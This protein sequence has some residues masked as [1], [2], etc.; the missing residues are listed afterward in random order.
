M[1]PYLVLDQYAQKFLQEWDH[2]ATVRSQKRTRFDDTTID[3]VSADFIFKPFIKFKEIQ[4]LATENTLT[5]RLQF[6][7]QLLHSVANFEVNF[8]TDLCGKLANDSIGIDLPDSVKQVALLIGTDEMYHAFVARE[9]LGDLKKLRG[10]TPIT[11]SAQPV[12]PTEKPSSE[13]LPVKPKP[14]PLEFFKTDVPVE[15][16][17]IG[18]TTLLCILENA[19]VDDL[20]NM[21][22]KSNQNPFDIYVREHMDDESRHKV[23]FQQLLKYIWVTISEEDRV[24]LGKT[25][26][27]YF[28]NYVN[29]DREVL[30]NLRIKALAG[31]NLSEQKIHEIA[32][33]SVDD[34]LSQAKY[35]I[36]FVKNPMKL[37]HYAG[38]TQH[39]PTRDLLIAGNWLSS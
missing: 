34:Q 21:S 24:Y 20:I 22:K 6:L 26:Y 19:I 35:D 30:L 13:A 2:K 15:L 10:I 39:P 3:S 31:L 33:A 23:F 9:L 32:T 16:S 11:H 18:E 36:D 4:E 29:V 38:I 7:C 14:T 12:L 25:I 1:S 28:E 5:Y 27:G 37:M 17:R 8:V